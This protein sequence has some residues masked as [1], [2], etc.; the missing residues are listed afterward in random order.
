MYCVNTVLTFLGL[1]IMGIV[2]FYLSKVSATV[3][4]STFAKKEEISSAPIY[5]AHTAIL[6]FVGICAGIQ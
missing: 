6:V 2:F 4:S 5:N 1:F 3:R